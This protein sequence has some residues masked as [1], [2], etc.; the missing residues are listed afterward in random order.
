MFLGFKRCVKGY[1]L[2]DSE[3]KKIVL[4]R[5]VTFDGTFMR[6]FIGIHQVESMKN[7]EVSHQKEIDATPYSLGCSV[8]CE[9]P[10]K[11]T[12]IEHHVADEDTEDNEI[13]K[14]NLWCS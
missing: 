12:R 14:S 6:Q 7:K 10:A 3:D 13:H 5:D 11:V 9:I 4:S 8:S 1:M 2:W